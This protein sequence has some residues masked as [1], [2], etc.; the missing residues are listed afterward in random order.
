F[1]RALARAYERSGE[2]GLA[3]AVAR[4]TRIPA[5]RMNLTDRGEVRTGACADLVVFDPRTLRDAAS[6]A[7]P[8]RYPEGI[9]H[10][11]VAGAVA[12]ENGEPTGARAGEVLRR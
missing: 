12:F 1:A 4:A 2:R 8:E 9:R 6:Y 10:V 7:E 11:V 5:S 3:D